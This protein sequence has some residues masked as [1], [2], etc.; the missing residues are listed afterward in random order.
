M[1]G[2]FECSVNQ[3]NDAVRGAMKGSPECLAVSLS[4]DADSR[5]WWWHVLMRKMK[6]HRERDVCYETMT[7]VNAIEDELLGLRF[8]PHPSTK[9]LATCAALLR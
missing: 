1:T 2:H 6:R 5:G 4:S 3:Y 7:F 9:S 8:C